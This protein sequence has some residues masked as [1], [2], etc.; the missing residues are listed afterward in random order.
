MME[1]VMP[2]LCQKGAKRDP[3]GTPRSSQKRAKIEDLPGTPLGP[4]NGAKMEP[5]STQNGSKMEPRWTPNGAK[6]NEHRIQKNAK[7]NQ[8]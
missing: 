1:K 8:N 3:N 4:Q 7:L 6:M 2:K 5:K